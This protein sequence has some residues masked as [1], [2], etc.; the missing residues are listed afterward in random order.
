LPYDWQLNAVF[1]RSY[2]GVLYVLGLA[3]VGWE[4]FM[5]IE[6]CSVISNHFGSRSM[7]RDE[8]AG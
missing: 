6:A 3:T 8:N 7:S 1:H 2:W 5:L 4:A